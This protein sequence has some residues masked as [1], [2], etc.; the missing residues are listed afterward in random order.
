[1]RIPTDKYP[2]PNAPDNNVIFYDDIYG[3]IIEEDLIKEAAKFF[4]MYDEEE[5]RKLG[6]AQ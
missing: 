1:V 4:K 6:G 2:A 5:K 3:V